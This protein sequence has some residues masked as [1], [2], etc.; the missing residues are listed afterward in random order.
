MAIE[1]IFRALE[2]QADD[3]VNRILHAATVQADAV[4]HEARDEAERI[5]GAKVQAADVAVQAKAAKVVNAAR[6]QVKRDLAQVR[7]SAVEAVFEEAAQ[8][9]AA[10]RGTPEYEKVFAQ[11]M[12]EA[13]EGLD[14]ECEIQVAPS[15]SEL[16]Q[17]IATDLGLT[18]VVSP[19]LD[20][21]GGLIV[22]THDARV[23]RRNT[24]ETRLQK[25]STVAGTRVAEVLTS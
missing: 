22:S 11:L 20:T 19:T 4:E 12:K 3:E 13:C 23:V 1:D 2:E 14:G 18:F 8:R 6:L 9:L 16:A 10:M 24:F 17:K 15:D 7:D 25:A 5:T 21:I